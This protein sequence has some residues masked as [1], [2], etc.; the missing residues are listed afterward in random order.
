[1]L[2]KEIMT[3]NVITISPEASLKEVGRVLKEKKVS[4]LPVT[5]TAGTVV[6]I[7]TLTDLWRVLHRIYSWKGFEKTEFGAQ[8]ND[9]LEQEKTNSKVKDIMTKTVIS[10]SEDDSIDDAMRMMFENQIHT[11]PVTKDGRLIGIVGK[12]DIIY[13]AF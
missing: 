7:I 13:N 11:I 2:I 6:G 4:G 8:F 9:M 5:N 12:R 1:M 10:L 3:T